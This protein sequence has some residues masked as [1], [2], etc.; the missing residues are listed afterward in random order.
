MAGITSG[1]T[2]EFRGEEPQRGRTAARPTKIGARGY[3]DVGA[4]LKRDVKADDVSLLAAGVAFYAMLALVP[5]LVAL[6]SVYGLVADPNDI[7]RNVDDVLSAAPQEVRDLVSSQLSSIVESSPSGL[8]LGALAGL[9]VA[10]WSASAGV[11]NLMTAINRAYHEEETRGFVKLRGTA[12]LLTIGLLV[13]GL[14]ALAGL[15]IWPQTLGSSGGE[16]VLRTTVMIVRW[17]LAALVVVT[18][19][20]VLYRFAPDRDSPRW[21]WASPGA[22][23]ATVL[24]LVAS[25]GFSIY[26]ANFGKYNET[27]GA[28]GAIVVVILWL[29]IGAY[30]VIL[31]AELNGELEHQTAHDTTRGRPEPMGTRDAYVADNLGETADQVTATRPRRRGLLDRLRDRRQRPHRVRRA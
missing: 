21:N 6:V 9:V 2:S 22:I 31:G 13:F 29:Y 15:V 20:A 18:A 12:L 10:L 7:G 4:R 30:A 27:Y 19:L 17:P 11:K 25:V 16:G 8:R 3:R 14:A 5:S 28:L 26:A 1:S 23:V 24:W